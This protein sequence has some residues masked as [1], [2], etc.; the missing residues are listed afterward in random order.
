MALSTL[1]RSD[2]SARQLAEIVA[3]TEDLRRQRADLERLRGQ[4]E[5]SSAETTLIVERI[6]QLRRRLAGLRVTD[7][8][9]AS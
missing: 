5:V 7:E 3:I 6:E 1:S 2:D 9:G 8:Q 4:S